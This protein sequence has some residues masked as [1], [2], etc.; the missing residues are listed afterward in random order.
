ML[1][2]SLFSTITHAVLLPKHFFFP[3][4]N[5]K[6][7]STVRLIII[8]KFVYY[9]F[10]YVSPC[11]VW[12]AYFQAIRSSYAPAILQVQKV[13]TCPL[14]PIFRKFSLKNLKILQ[15]RC[16]SVSIRRRHPQRLVPTNNNKYI[17]IIIVLFT[18]G[19]KLRIW[20]NSY[21]FSFLCCKIFIQ[22][23]N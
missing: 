9:T 5:K 6:N 21:K 10:K 20:S 19:K 22:R 15:G 23:Q 14:L 17:I 16:R 18:I 7:I 2:V 13:W 4:T 8:C 3:H 11:Q 1:L 12:A